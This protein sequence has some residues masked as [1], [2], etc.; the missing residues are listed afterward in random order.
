MFGY[1]R[2]VKNNCDNYLFKSQY[3]SLCKILGNR[4]GLF[5]RL[6]LSYDIS[7]LTLFLHAFSKKAY[8]YQYESCIIHPFHKRR[9][10]RATDIDVFAADITVY[11]AQKKIRD[12]IKDERLIKKKFYQLINVLPMKWN[13]STDLERGE[14]N[15]LF[16]QLDK[17]EDLKQPEVDEMSNCF[18]K[19][20]EK[21]ALYVADT[22]AISLPEKFE[23]LVFLLGKMIYTLDAFEDLEKDIKNWHYNPLIYE[24]KE[25]I[26]SFDKKGNVSKEIKK[27]ELWRLKL[28]LDHIRYAYSF[29]GEKL[30]VY[31]CEIDG[32]IS[33]SL[34]AM[35]YR[36]MGEEL[37]CQNKGDFHE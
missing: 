28:L 18:G 24:N 32:I 33:K 14:I 5:A 9:I 26:L 13:R 35:L 22:L 12:D 23:Q 29:I 4:Y 34:P 2:P 11:F 25:L 27:R 31:R 30:G 16:S 20:L 37:N 10:K 6:F 19:I 7:L 3:C 1:I 36:V 17:M 15:N 21:T 8:I